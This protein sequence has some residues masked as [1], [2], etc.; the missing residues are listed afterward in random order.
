MYFDNCY[1]CNFKLDM[2]YV[3]IIAAILLAAIGLVGAIVPGIAGPPFS[4]LGLLVLSFVDGIDYSTSFLVIMGIYNVYSAKTMLGI[5]MIVVGIAAPILVRVGAGNQIERDFDKLSEAGGTHFHVR[6]YEDRFEAQNDTSHG[7]HEYAKLYK[8]VETDDA[9][10]L[11][12]EMGHSVIIQKK[13]C[14]DELIAFLKTLENHLAA[15]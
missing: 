15:E 10:Y 5:F 12:V 11:E 9:F 4:F 2:T 8:V 3:L 13:N 7:V 1:L 6:F 14:S